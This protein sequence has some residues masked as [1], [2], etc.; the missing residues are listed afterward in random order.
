MHLTS[1]VKNLVS[2][3][4][5]NGRDYFTVQAI[6]MLKGAYQGRGIIYS[7]MG[8]LEGDAWI[9]ADF[10]L[11]QVSP[12][13]YV[14]DE[15]GSITVEREAQ[16]RFPCSGIITSTGEGYVIGPAYELDPVR[17]QSIVL[18]FLA[19][20]TTPYNVSVEKPVLAISKQESLVT[21]SSL[22]GEVRCLGT[23]SSSSKVARI[24]LNRNPGLTALGEGFNET[25]SELRGGGMF[26]FT[27][28][29]AT[30][31]FEELVLAF[32]P[33]KMFSDDLY[34]WGLDRI[35][36]NL[37]A[38]DQQNGEK[39][40]DYVIGDGPEVDYRLRLTIDRGL[41]RHESDE[42]RITVT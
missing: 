17:G 11:S 16:S 37:G 12:A 35:A 31:T 2:S 25:L 32:Y 14:A 34:S 10:D 7:R 42:T 30:R 39:P 23:I 18:M 21:L 40:S 36:S 1:Y 3:S 5:S 15:S 24:I 20:R 27:W 13:T 9:G 29:P 26:S 41:G 6:G 4:T 33:S 8:R 38:P 22:G 19:A 28:K